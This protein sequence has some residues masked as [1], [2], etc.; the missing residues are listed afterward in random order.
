MTS[1][2]DRQGNERPLDNLY[3][4]FSQ[5]GEY[6]PTDDEKIC[7]ALLEASTNVGGI[8]WEELKKKGFARFTGLGGNLEL[9]N[10]TEIPA[11]DTITPLTK[12]V[13]EKM[14]SR[15]PRRSMVA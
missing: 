1:F 11:D 15:Y 8:Q 5:S 3:E 6:G 2:V 4:K 9:G 14:P 13:F 7:A 10:A 12:H